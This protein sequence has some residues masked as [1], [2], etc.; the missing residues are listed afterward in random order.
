MSVVIG[1]EEDMLFFPYN[2]EED[3]Y[4]MDD[5]L[6]DSQD[7]AD[8]F[9]QFIGNGVYPNPASGLKVESAYNTHVLTVRMGAAFLSG[10]F[11]L[12]K[13][14]FDFPVDASHLTLGRRDIVVCRHDIVARTAQLHYIAGTPASIPQTPPI[15]RTDDVFDLKLCEI[16]IN[17]NSQRISQSNILDTRPDSGVCGFVT[18]L[19]H[20]VDTSELYSQYKIYLDEQIS[21]WDG[22]RD[23]QEADWQNQ[24]DRQKDDFREMFMSM[25][26]MYQAL[27]TQSFTL[28]NNNFD[29]WSVRRG[30]RKDT[31]FEPGGDINET[32]TVIAA[33]FVMATK[34]TIFNGDGSITETVTF[35]P[36]TLEESALVGRT[37]LTTEFT[38]SKTTAFN[39]DGSITETIGGGE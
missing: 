2:S 19:I 34:A 1:A 27:E 16:T 36:W 24:T 22:I 29:D 31:I 18:G 6:Y 3:E 7:W 15:I 38:I 11:Y 14:D 20:Q 26:L 5:R 17:P 33:G 8:Y 30:C 37:I 25:A 4:G 32:I 12:Q 39:E 21:L 35:H 28:I 10:R 9:K 13:K 23:T